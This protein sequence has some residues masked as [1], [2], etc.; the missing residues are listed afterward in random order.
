[1]QVPQPGEKLRRKY[2]RA[3]DRYQNQFLA[4]ELF[5][6]FVVYRKGRILRVQEAFGRG[7]ERELGQSRTATDHHSH[8]R[9]QYLPVMT[10][11]ETAKAL[12]VSLDTDAPGCAQ[13]PGRRRQYIFLVRHP[14]LNSRFG[15]MVLAACP[16]IQHR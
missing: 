5:A 12:E 15:F 6:K 13:G 7:I 1:M 14:L 9:Q 8:D 16:R 10:E 2:I 4:T 11:D 3:R